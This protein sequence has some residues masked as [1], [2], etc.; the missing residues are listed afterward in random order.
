M[1][2]TSYV[3]T[4]ALMIP[5]DVSEWSLEDF[6]APRPAWQARGACRDE[7]TALFFVER[8]GDPRPAREAC[9]G[10]PVKGPC[11]DYAMADRSIKGTWGGTS[12]RERQ[13]MR[14]EVADA[15]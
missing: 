3:V 13:R 5:G 6:A 4:K 2:A 9:A 12:E 14:G 10:C 7:E 8:G 1:D 15:A 11:L